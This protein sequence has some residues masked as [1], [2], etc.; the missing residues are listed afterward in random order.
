MDDEPAT[1]G[2]A[3]LLG[4][5]IGATAGALLGLLSTPRSGA[6]TRRQ[7][8][9]RSLR[10]RPAPAGPDAGDAAAGSAPAADG[11]RP[12]SDGQPL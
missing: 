4:L 9:D 12:P 5:L 6:Q 11:G 3:F 2:G 1:A 10:L 7:L 8:K